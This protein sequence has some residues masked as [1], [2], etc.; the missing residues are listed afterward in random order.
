MKDFLINASV[1]YL[2]IIISILFLGVK[3]DEEKN[4]KLLFVSTLRNLFLLYYSLYYFLDFV[5]NLLFLEHF[6]YFVH[7]L[8][9]LEHFLYFVHNLLFLEHFQL[10]QI[11]TK[12]KLFFCILFFIIVFLLHTSTF[13]TEFRI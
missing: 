13:R 4:L 6:L 12:S 9:P 11:Q 2:I 3:L 5:H 1:P 7:S 10:K 8:L